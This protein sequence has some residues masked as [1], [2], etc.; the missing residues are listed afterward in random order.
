MGMEVCL[1]IFVLF[2]SSFALLEAKTPLVIGKLHE[3][4]VCSWLLCFC[5]RLM[6]FFCSSRSIDKY[7]KIDLDSY[8]FCGKD[9]Q[10]VNSA[11]PFFNAKITGYKLLYIANH[12]EKCH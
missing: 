5:M 1:G 4:R 3:E 10:L 8:F 2:V 9:D 7:N 11:I 6:S 12:G